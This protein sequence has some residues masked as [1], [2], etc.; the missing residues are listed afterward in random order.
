MKPIVFEDTLIVV[1]DNVVTVEAVNHLN[2]DAIEVAIIDI[3]IEI[4]QD[5]T[6]EGIVTAIWTAILEVDIVRDV[7]I[8]EVEAE[9]NLEDE[10]VEAGLF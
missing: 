9:V 8:A 1:V 5:I 6:I 3:R 2:A 7:V 10:E 4:E